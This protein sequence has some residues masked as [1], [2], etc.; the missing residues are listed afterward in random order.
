MT[1]H[2]SLDLNYTLEQQHRSV[3][4]CS[5][6]GPLRILKSLYPEGDAICHNVLVH[7]PGGLVGG[8]TLQI[9]AQVQEGAHAV[10]TT[11]GATRFYRSAG[12][13]ATQ[14]TTLDLAANARIEWLPLEALA[15]SGCIAINRLTMNLKPG[16]ELIGW[17]VTALGL[18]HARQ[19]FVHGSFSQHI[20]VPGSWLEQGKISAL[21]DRL[22][23][24]PLGLNGLRCLA[25]LFFIA[26]QPLPRA[27]K[28]SAL[29][30][31]WATIH[32]SPLAA[33]AGVTS[34]NPNVLVV[35]ALAD[36]AEPVMQLLKAVRIA[37][38]QELW[39]ISAGTPRI[40]AM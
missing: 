15:Y 36:Q 10:L 35:R 27:R 7:P 40:W 6:A 13:A 14:C 1:W 20:E 21:D 24:S 12:D 28:E 33:T 34:P 31:A 9:R 37:W 17:D 19:P 39:G 2:A 23:N 26:G 16:A 25:S 22:L 18:P 38:R 29:E 11:P 4:R 3:L 32:A 5:H 30:L 8:D